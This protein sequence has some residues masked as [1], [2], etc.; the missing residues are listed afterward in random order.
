[1]IG[2]TVQL[3]DGSGG[4]AIPKFNQAYSAFGEKIDDRFGDG[5]SMSTRYQYAGGWG[6]ESGL[7]VLEGAEGSRP[8]ELLHVGARWYDPA[9]GRFVQRDPIGIEGGINVYVY[10]GN[11]PVLQ[12]D[13]DGTSEFPTFRTGGGYR[14]GFSDIGKSAIKQLKQANPGVNPKVIDSMKGA[15]LALRGPGGPSWHVYLRNPMLQSIPKAPIGL[16]L[17]ITAVYCI[18]VAAVAGTVGYQISKRSGFGD[19]LGDVLCP[20]QTYWPPWPPTLTK[21]V[22]Y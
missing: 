9:I 16:G 5:E 7:I 13:P 1:M 2:S 4:P 15:R 19:W 21:P 18:G 17:G 10:C 20:P 3:S 14:F 6:Y 22:I 8:I 12:V 11:E